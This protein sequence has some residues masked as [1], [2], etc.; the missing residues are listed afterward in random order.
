MAFRLVSPAGCQSIATTETVAKHPVGLTASGT[1][2]V[3]GRGEFIYLK[4]VASTVVGSWVDYDLV[5]NTTALAPA[6]AGVGQMAVAMSA[7]VANQFGWYQVS[8]VADVKSPNA[9]AVAADVHM[10]AATPGSTDDAAVA[11]EQVLNAKYLSTTGVPSTGLARV[12][13]ERPF[14]Q[15]QI[16]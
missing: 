3:F 12:Q 9:T 10:L 15:G 11:G 13:I 14:H 6:T 1:D 4:G 7:N 2:P 5:A 16:T 8:G